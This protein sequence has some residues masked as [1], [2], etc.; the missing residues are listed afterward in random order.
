LRFVKKVS[1]E[2]EDDLIDEI[3]EGVVIPK[4]KGI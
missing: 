2:K 3:L 1:K 4:N